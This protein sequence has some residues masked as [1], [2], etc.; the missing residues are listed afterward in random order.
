MGRRPY[1]IAYAV[2]YKTGFPGTFGGLEPAL[3]WIPLVLNA[4]LPQS[5][6]GRLSTMGELTT[7]L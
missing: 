2:H 3:D 7:C 6:Q 4:S 1:H 5:I